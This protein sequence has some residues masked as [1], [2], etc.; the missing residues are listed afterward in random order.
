MKINDFAPQAANAANTLVELGN[1]IG[2]LHLSKADE[3][4]TGSLPLQIG[5]ESIVNSWIRN[6]MAY[7][8]QLVG[9]LNK[10][11]TQVQEIRAPLQ[12]ITSEVF[13][14]GIVWEPTV[15]NPDE[16]QLDE[17]NEFIGDAN[18]FHKT[19]E[20]VLRLAHFDLNSIDDA[21]ILLNKS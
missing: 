20:E 4:S 16:S 2:Q 12:H 10:I 18:R 3:G 19:L 17:I 15:N 1:Q 6:Q 21:F 5:I 13:R 11:A 9:D 14:R 8:T 7:R